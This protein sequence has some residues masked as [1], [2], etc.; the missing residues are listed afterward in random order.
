MM[1]IDSGG[2]FD[3]AYNTSQTTLN[4]DHIVQ[5]VGYGQEHGIPYWIVRNSWGV[6][7][8]E[9]GFIRVRRGTKDRVRSKERKKRDGESDK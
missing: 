1:M 3:S 6:D 4:V 5:L 8:G 7:F 2:I 9:G